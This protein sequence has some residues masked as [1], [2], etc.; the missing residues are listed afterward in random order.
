[1]ERKLWSPD[2]TEVT[3]KIWV[4]FTQTERYSFSEYLKAGWYLNMSVAID[5][6]ASNKDPKNPESLHFLPDYTEEAF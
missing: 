6:T 3:G 2:G 5:F 4:E 1:M